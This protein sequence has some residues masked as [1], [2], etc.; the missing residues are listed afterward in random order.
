MTMEPPQGLKKNLAKTYK[1]LN[2]DILNSCKKSVEYKKLI[3]CYSFFH[4]IILNRRKFGSI[5]W[6]KHYPFT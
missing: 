4:A 5:G 6:N 3:F 2:N 1:Y